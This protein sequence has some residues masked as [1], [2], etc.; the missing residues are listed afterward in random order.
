MKMPNQ[1]RNI[2]VING[3]SSAGKDTAALAFSDAK[4]IKFA[5]PGK[6]ALEFMYGLEPGFLDNRDKRN[7]VAP[8][9]GGK[10][11]LE[12]LIQFLKHKDKLVGPDLF[13]AQVRLEMIKAL[14]ASDITI[15]DMRSPEELRVV[16]G[17]TSFANVVPI[18]VTGGQELASDSLQRALCWEL[19]K[20]TAYKNPFV[21]HNDYDRAAAFVFAVADYRR[22]GMF[23]PDELTATL[24]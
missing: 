20:A 21:L 22:Q 2:Y 17:F 14:A 7:R 16:L 6:R 13:P 10:T 9:S 23:S 12:V 11:Y 3:F 15:T 19:A 1:K 5:A 4:T 18:W 24:T 8:F